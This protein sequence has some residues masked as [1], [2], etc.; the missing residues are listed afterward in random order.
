MG[1]LVL[2]IVGWILGKFGLLLLLVAAYLLAPSVKDF[3]EVL[4]EFDPVS[5][6][7]EA[8]T[9]IGASTPGKD[10]PGEEFERKVRSL[11]AGLEQKMRNRIEL[12]GQT[13]FLPT[14]STVR[15]AKLY[16]LDLEIEV[17]G[18]ALI[19]AQALGKGRPACEGLGRSNARLEEL[20]ASEAE[21][22]RAKP[23][24]MF[25][26]K[27]H[28][29]LRAQMESVEKAQK[30]YAEA[31]RTYQSLPGAFDP[32]PNA[33]RQML[34]MKHGKF[35]AELEALKA[36]RSRLLQ[37]ILGVL[38][39]A[40]ITL[41]AII[42]LPIGA[43]LAAFYGVAVLASR[44]FGVQLL[45]GSSGEL[46]MQSAAQP[47]QRIDLDEGWELLID[48]ALLRSSPDSAVKRTKLILDWSMP[49]S[50]LAAGLYLLTRIRATG[51]GTITI[52]AGE[53]EH[54]EIAVLDLPEKSALVLRP[55]CLAGIVQRI[56]TPLRITR[57]WRLG[58]L[59]SW[60][61]LQVRYIVFHGPA[62][63][64]VK[65]NRGV[66]VDAARAGT[67]VNQAATLGFS[68][69]L[70]YGVARSG[71][72]YAYQSGKK[73]LFDDCFSSGPGYYV[74]E[75]RPR[76]VKKT[77]LPGRGIEGIVNSLLKICGI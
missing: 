30:G 27:E 39:T 3:W 9:K 31:C 7:R 1:K 44:K 16:A 59:G 66:Q 49:L 22:D 20:S 68:A 5:V 64:I 2:K 61:T 25:R 8:G 76:P 28:S 63:L 51:G 43:K 67:S 17:I 65:G 70:A 18:R 50:S 55:R 53:E 45:P 11:Q 36:S 72:F 42:L 10:T 73:E 62:K 56:D 38:P 48:P 13:C 15:N 74:H 52:S 58:S 37:L 12:D 77:L 54:S 6:A 29:A 60:L 19:Y 35:L 75:V 23:H 71:T 57:H 69:N 33:V 40:A 24:W 46:A 21:L 26:S 41:A 34:G 4:V 32:E 14:C 47:L